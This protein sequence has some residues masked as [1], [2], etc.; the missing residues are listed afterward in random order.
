VRAHQLF[1]LPVVLGASVLPAQVT[2]KPK[3][4][5]AR[6]ADLVVNRSW[7]LDKGE[8]VVIF[9][10]PADDHGFAAPLRAAIEKAGADYRELTPPPAAEFKALT[11][12][13][14]AAREAEWEALFDGADA[15]IWLPMRQ[16]PEGR[17]FERLVEKTSVRSIHYHW[18]L[19]PDAAEADTVERLYAAAIAVSPEV[20]LGRI[21]AIE[22]AVRG[23]TVRVTA[24]NGT[25]LTFEIPASAWVHRN[26]GDASRD[27]VWDARSVRDREEELPASV[28]RTT[29]IRNA[30]GTLVGYSSFDTRSPALRAMLIGGKVVRLEGLQGQPAVVKAWEAATGEKDLPGEFVIGTNPEL[31]AVLRSGFMPY[32]GYGAGV[33][34][35][36]IGDNWESGGTNRS[37]N[38]ELLLFLP[39]ATV[40]A[41]GVVLVKD[42]KLQLGQ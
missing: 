14:R 19:P 16:I 32:Y 24:P 20:I 12:A 5:H 26:T 10:D 1:L 18:F 13:D 28:F 36:A 6:L 8:R 41:N 29:D 4:D 39:G 22:R 2:T 11:P 37:S 15:A 35:L 9:W 7:R 40:S 33:V 34:R 27:K 31:P 42:G 38:G 17:L 25:D 23:A 3:V 21:A 30:R